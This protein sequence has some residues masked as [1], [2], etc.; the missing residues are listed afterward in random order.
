MDD[1]VWGVIN[2][3]FCAFKVSTPAKRNFCRNEFNA[4]GICNRQSCPLANSRYAT[5]R[6]TGG[7]LYLYQ[8]TIERAHMP[9]RLWE[10]RLLPRNYERALALIDE[11]LQFHPV[12][13]KHK[14][15]QRLTK[16]TQYMIRSRRLAL[17][18][19]LPTLVGI[20]K[21]Q[22]RREAGREK[23]ALAAARLE[24]VIEKELVERLKSGAYGDAPLNVN[25]EVWQ[26]V[27]KMQSA[28]SDEEDVASEE[29]EEVEG[30]E[31]VEDDMEESDMDA[32][33]G[34]PGIEIE[35]EEEM[36]RI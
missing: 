3:H 4:S 20:K 29:E 30:P 28:Q 15:K 6:E 26:K 1:I 21:K 10:R 24:K 7:R 2:N 35:Y 8:K 19:D 5:V 18:E 31:Y 34:R 32:D 16:L 11:E 9:S 23:K 12:F 33:G 27:L 17:R 22:T 14:C 13:Q 25:E 36:E